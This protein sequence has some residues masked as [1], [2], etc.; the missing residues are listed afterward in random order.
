[1]S[2]AKAPS[3]HGGNP[4]LEKRREGST[5][6]ELYGVQLTSQRIG[7]RFGEIGQLAGV[8][9]V[10]LADGL[11][12]GLRVLEVRTGTGFRFEVLAG[13]GL[14]IGVAEYRGVPI[15]WRSPT[16]DVAAAHFETQGTG[17]LRSF[18]GGLLV[19]CGLRWAGEQSSDGE[20]PLGL[21]GRLSNTP[22]EQVITETGWEA[23]QYVMRIRGS[24]REARVLRENLILTRTITSRLGDN[25]F[26]VEDV[27]IN[28]GFDPTPHMFLYHINLGFPVVS[29]DSRLVASIAAVDPKDENSSDVAHV[30]QYGP[31]DRARGYE[32]YFLDLR[33]ASN[34]LV[35]VGIVRTRPA[36][37]GVAIA[38]PKA[39]FPYFAEWKV[40][41]PGTYVVG[42]EPGNAL[43]EG[44]V[45]ERQK[46]RLQTLQPGEARRYHLRF[47]VLTT[48]T[49]IEEFVGRVATATP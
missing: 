3:I 21:H 2:L 8:R 44:M 33:P 19:G 11:A 7:E 48:N 38:Y 31:P 39:E 47:S 32:T 22:A 16:G 13:R 35:E 6:L 1:M 9:P 5:V 27:V 10:V 36:P 4:P 17:W 45:V 46:G 26:E 41:R 29:E 20:E 24:V 15:A 25:G 40:C 18:H 28:A 43:V 23:G 34:G 42:L 37:L 14:D 49:E 30:G 12:E